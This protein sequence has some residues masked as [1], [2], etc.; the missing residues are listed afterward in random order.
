[1]ADLSDPNSST[2]PAFGRK[3]FVGLSAG[4]AAAVTSRATALAESSPEF[5]KPHPPIVAENDPAI[6][7]QRVKLTRPDATLDAYA[8]WPKDA[9]ATTPGIVIVQHIWGVDST[10][11]DAVRRYAKARFLCI[12]PDL[13]GRSNTPPGDG[14]S[15]VSPFRPA[16]AALEDDVVKGDLLAARSWIVGR[17]ANAKVGITGFCMGGGRALKQL[18]GTADYAAASIFYGPVQQAAP[19]ASASADPFAYGAQISTPVRGNYGERDT[20][21]AAADVRA[22][23][24]R[25]AGPHELDIYPAAGHAFFDDTRTSYVG[26]AA[27]DAWTKTLAWFHRYLA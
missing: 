1:M 23:F 14:T 20:S 7:T 18:I 25:L 24:A 8:A 12:A 21:I 9:T 4:A 6:E 5:G 11:R 27:T 26:T 10:I 16:A 17:A 15:D 13:Y 3:T 2:S 19:G 22:L